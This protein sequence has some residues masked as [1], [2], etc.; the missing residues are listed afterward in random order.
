MRGTPFSIKIVLY[1]DHV[2]YK[3]W[4]LFLV[5]LIISLL[6]LINNFDLLQHNQDP[7]LFF[8][9]VRQIICIFLGREYKI[10]V[11]HV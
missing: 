7:N 5:T 1:I 2:Y 3:D 6:V 4:F 11:D 9:L 10:P 8:F